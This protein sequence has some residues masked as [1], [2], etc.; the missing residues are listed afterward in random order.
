MKNILKSFFLITLVISFFS[1]D[2]N[3]GSNSFVEEELGWVQFMQN[4]DALIQINQGFADEIVLDLNIQVPNTSSDLT[5]KYDLVSIS[6]LNPNTVYGTSTVVP[7]G[8][9][10]WSGPD[11]N[12]GIN[13]ANLGNITFNLLQLPALTEPM[14]FDVVLTGTSLSTVTAGVA[15]ESFKTTQRI[16]I[17]PI[18]PSTSY[19]GD[20]YSDD[21]GVPAG[22][23]APYTVN[24]VPVAGETNMWTL[25][26]TWGPDF[27]NA[28]C[29]G[30][31]PPGS[32][33]YPS[34][35]SI[36]DDGSVLVTGAAGYATGGTGTYNGCTDTF[37][38][39]ISQGLFTGTFTVDV[40]LTGNGD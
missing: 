20:A 3:D 17:G 11:N 7:A 40:V 31:V 12:T 38:L 25:D 16:C 23:F 4:S 19:A 8:V 35:I 36:E 33:P 10:S 32:F 18:S 34:T 29:G 24:L 30:C 5:V 37:V 6:G 39:N 22:A 14:E 26:S 15:G 9:T 13:Y 28:L 1:C 2:D 21:L 27:V